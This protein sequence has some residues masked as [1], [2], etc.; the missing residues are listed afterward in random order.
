M[1]ATVFAIVENLLIRDL[2][3]A[4]QGKMLVSGNQQLAI[5]C[6]L[7]SIAGGTAPVNHNLFIMLL[8]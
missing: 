3:A 4:N 7:K 1:L 8:D 2:P 5:V 6:A